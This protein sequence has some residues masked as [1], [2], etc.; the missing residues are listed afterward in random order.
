M[1]NQIMQWYRKRD[2]KPDFNKQSCGNE[3][4]TTILLPS[5]KADLNY[6]T[7]MAEANIPKAKAVNI[8]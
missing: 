1:Y 8:W 3:V 6:R 2:P 7:D 5:I 4:D